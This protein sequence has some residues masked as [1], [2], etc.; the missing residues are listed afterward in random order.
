[1]KY[2]KQYEE[3]G[4]KQFFRIG[5]NV[6][7]LYS[8]YE[9]SKDGYISGKIYKICDTDRTCPDYQYLITKIDNNYF[10]SNRDCNWV[11]IDQIRLAE[12]HELIA[13][14]YNL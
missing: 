4:N 14:K 1:M 11:K 3:V 10:E 9:S 8:D 7:L 5:D 6:I 12:P 13:N 2:I